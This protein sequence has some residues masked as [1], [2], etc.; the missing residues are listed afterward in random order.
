MPSASLGGKHAR[1][2]QEIFRLI[3]EYRANFS[4]HHSA[5]VISD[6]YEIIAA[7]KLF[8]EI[9]PSVL[10][11]QKLASGLIEMSGQIAIYIAIT[12]INNDAVSA[13]NK[14]NEKEHN[15]DHE[16]EVTPISRRSDAAPTDDGLSD[17]YVCVDVNNFFEL[18]MLPKIDKVEMR[19]S[20]SRTFW[21]PA[22]RRLREDDRVMYCSPN[23]GVDHLEFAIRLNP[24]DGAACLRLLVS[25][26]IDDLQV[27][28]NTALPPYLPQKLRFRVSVSGANFVLEDTVPPIPAGF[29]VWQAG[30]MIK[31][32]A[33]FLPPDRRPC[34]SDCVAGEGSPP[35]T[36]SPWSSSSPPD[37]VIDQ[38]AKN[39]LFPW[40]MG[41]NVY[42]SRENTIGFRGPVYGITPLR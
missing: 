31:T 23:S 4:N 25:S 7:H 35:C 10:Q 39:S 30:R 24:R 3:T 15:A 11:K 18:L 26:L 8:K 9:M 1:D 42:C 14:T 34:R 27:G 40:G 17:Y 22:I 41:A 28:I 38:S 19:Y 29:G 2:L 21:N 37:I 6:K 13:H 32:K 36:T 20:I 33:F 5:Q 12:T 16:A